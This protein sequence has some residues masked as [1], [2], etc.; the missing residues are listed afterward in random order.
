MLLWDSGLPTLPSLSVLHHTVGAHPLS[1]SR[2]SVF[3]FGNKSEVLE[4]RDPHGVEQAFR[5]YW[6]TKV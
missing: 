4:F 3:D 6:E 1:K 5:L 2:A